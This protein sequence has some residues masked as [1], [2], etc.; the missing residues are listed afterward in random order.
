MNYRFVTSINKNEYDA[1]VQ[2]S[3]YVNLLQSYDWALIKHN[4]KHIYTGVYKD[5]KLV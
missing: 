5:E 4:W 1:F 3:P 2:S